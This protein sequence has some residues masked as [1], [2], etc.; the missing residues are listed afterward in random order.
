MTSEEFADLVGLSRD[1]VERYR[2][3]GLLDP[4]NDGLLDDVD[5]V[6]LDFVRHRLTEGGYDPES[7]ASA[8]RDGRVES[9]YGRQLFEAG[10]PLELHEAVARTGLAPE[11]IEQLIAALGLSWS[12]LRQSDVEILDILRVARDAGLP[13]E[14][15]LGVT[16]V[17]GDSL[18]R[19]AD[20][21]IRVVHVYIHERLM[22]EGAS[23]EEVERLISGMETNLGPLID[24]MI[25]R[26]HRGYLVE[27]AMEDAF[28]HLTESDTQAKELGS[29]EATIAFVDIA[30][31][32]ALAEARGDDNA[33]RVLDR[34]D[35]I[36][37]PLL[38]EHDGKLVKQVG[39]GFMVAFRDPAHAVQFAIATQA[40]LGRDPDLPAIRVGINTGPALYR[41]GDYIG[42]AVN[43]AS[44]VVSSAM[45]GQ[46]LLT[47]PVAT[48]AT[49]AGID[50]EELGVRMMRGV[51]DPLALYRVSPT[52]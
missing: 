1:E 45:P 30:S 17:V 36:V 21:E 37:R 47:E 7:L 14:A 38:V 19:I 49:K 42:S 46:I 27:A 39:D 13:W 10:A 2:A 15:V 24:P 6:R 50:V 20:T 4:E 41:T 33:M 18:R 28:F 44:R 12:G 32:T 35:V 31:F 8:I 40:E 34:I 26:L 51:D 5:L 29:V 22:A 25:Q 43:V 16:R 23:E 3:L 9:M 48:A 52:P 11:Q